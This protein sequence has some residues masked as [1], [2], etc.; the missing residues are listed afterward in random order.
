MRPK[1]PVALPSWAVSVH[2]TT[3]WLAAAATLAKYC[4]P[5]VKAL[6]RKSAA[7]TGVPDASKRRPKM[8]LPS[9]SW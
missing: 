7:P 3:N 2:T 1:T 6:T 8:P 9:P 4:D 5:V